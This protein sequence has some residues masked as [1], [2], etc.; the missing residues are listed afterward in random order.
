[1]KTKREKEVERGNYFLLSE[2][3][4]ETDIPAFSNIYNTETKKKIAANNSII[5]DKKM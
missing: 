4:N 3:V 1:M 5:E 2:T